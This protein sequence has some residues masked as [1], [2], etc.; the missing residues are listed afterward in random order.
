MTAKLKEH[1]LHDYQKEAG[2]YIMERRA[3]GL[4]L[5]M[6]LGKTVSTLT[7]INKLIYE[8]LELD[9]VLVIAPKRVAATVWRDEL[10]NWEHLEKLS[11]T[12]ISGSAKQRRAALREKTNI[13]TIG[14]E[15]VAWLV[16][17]YG[18]H[19]LPFDMLVIDESSSFKNHKSVR[20]KA[21]KRVVE[22][23]KKV[24]LLTGTPAPNGLIDLWAQIY[25]LDGG[26]R[27]GRFV[28]NYQKNYFNRAYNGFGFDIRKEAEGMIYKEI[29]DICMSMSAADYLELPERTTTDIRVELSAA[30]LA[31]YKAFERDKVLE[32]VESGEEIGALNAAGLANKLQQY[33]DGHVY[34]EDHNAHAVHA[35]KL[36]ALEE[37]IEAANGRPVL[38]GWA[39]R[40]TRDAIIKK[41]AKY[42]PRTMEDE[43]T[44]RDWNAGKIRVLLMHPASGGHGL[45][46]QAGGHFI[47]WA[48][49]TWSLELYQQFNARL[50]RQGQTHPVTVAHLITSGTIDRDIRR[51]LDGKKTKQNALLSAV[52]KRIDKYKNS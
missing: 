4:F 43:Q 17:E 38:I 11:I 7:A 23:F 3:S 6:G 50:D 26:Q 14:R 22:A 40:H 39:F 1:Q 44:I 41:L 24:V 48:G 12:V 52:K 21:L 25:L 45:N 31:A 5:D 33:A 20:F 47:I 42:N 37:F 27:L 18:G 49:L 10:Q 15:N 30:E 28:T 32:L 19:A 35:A 46:L 16:A 34:D 13:Y 8:E 36:D 51:A 9:T 2:R 29:E